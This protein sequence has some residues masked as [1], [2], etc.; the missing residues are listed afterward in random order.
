MAEFLYSYSNNII[1]K[2]HSESVDDYLK[3][4]KDL[5]F[6]DNGLS[7]ISNNNTVKELLIGENKIIII[8]YAF[9]SDITIE[10]YFAMVL[11]SNVINDV[12]IS[13]IKK[14]VHGSYI[15]LCS[16]ENIMYVF[17]DFLQTR[18]VFYSV[19]NNLISSSYKIIS[20][21]NDKEKFDEY[22]LFEYLAMR[23]IVYP[24]FVSNSTI[25]HDIFCLRAYEY[26]K[27]DLIYGHFDVLDLYIHINNKK[28]ISLDILSN[29]TA[30]ELNKIICN[31]KFKNNKIGLTLTGGFDS[32]LISTIAKDY[33][34]NSK[35]R[36]SVFQN[37]Y[38]KDYLIA[39]RISKITNKELLKFEMIPDIHIPL[40]YLVSDGFTPKEN[41]II[42]P[43]F[44]DNN[45]E[46]CFGGAFGTELYNPINYDS[47][48]DFIDG[49]LDNVKKVFINAECH[50]T[51][52]KEE[53][54]NE[55]EQINRHY[56]M[57]ENNERDLIRLFILNSTAKFS[58][59]MQ[60]AYNIFGLNFEPFGA[61]PIIELGMR[62]P[63]KTN[64]NNKLGKNFIIQKKIMY[65]LNKR[66]SL[67]LSTRYSPLSPLNLISFIPYVIGHINL[68]LDTKQR[69]KKINNNQI[70]LNYKDWVYF[71]DNWYEGFINNYIYHN[72]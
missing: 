60:S 31:P 30:K 55:F 45:F 46:L 18:N 12:L 53:L 42:S 15:I 56:L 54:Y 19:K 25:Y 21:S 1:N 3:L 40:L 58:S 65:R 36:I 35:Y 68:Y 17:S 38:S 10:E 4:F 69:S 22:K 66:I 11:H 9:C 39:S 26:I 43:L 72:N 27:I 51:Q 13:E 64:N 16:V 23:H 71:S 49:I 5:T 7:L 67:I 2:Y 14:K 41:S 28:N 34:I 70:K 32:R 33:Y 62:I 44:L 29:K 37:K 61:F 20:D 52:L 50:I 63:E 47:I 57:E 59:P 8:G 24:S 48:S 6:V